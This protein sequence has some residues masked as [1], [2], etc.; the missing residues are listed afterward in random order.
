MSKPSWACLENMLA[1]RAFRYI[2]REFQLFCQRAELLP[3]E[4]VCNCRLFPSLSQASNEGI[5]I[6]IVEQYDKDM[7][8]C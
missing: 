8:H 7:E 1:P 5:Y 2:L 6:K 3:M 4:N